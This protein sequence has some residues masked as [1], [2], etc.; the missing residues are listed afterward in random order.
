[1]ISY[2]NDLFQGEFEL[3]SYRS[4]NQHFVGFSLKYGMRLFVKCYPEFSYFNNEFMYYQA[5]HPN[6]LI[7]VDAK[8]L[9]IAYPYVDYQSVGAIEPRAL[10][11]M[12]AKFHNAAPKIVGLKSADFPSIRVRE[13]HGRMKEHAG[14]DQLKQAFLS[15]EPDVHV[16]DAEF[17]NLDTCVIH[18]DFLLNNI[19]RSN[20]ENVLI[21]FEMVAHD[22]AA[23]DC[24]GM[25]Q[26][27]LVDDVSRR[28]FVDGY[29]AIRPLQIPSRSLFR[30]LW[31]LRAMH[32]IDYGVRLRD[33]RYESLGVELITRLFAA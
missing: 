20:D 29:Q 5:T 14:Y 26:D 11:A 17:D 19:K 7:H 2:L 25:F 12:L 22:I 24:I 1:M 10:G 32:Y 18:G 28:A 23:A 27:T 15:I 30:V 33:L 4:H 16:A 8:K 9:L 21:D 13:L 6:A 3:T 31:F